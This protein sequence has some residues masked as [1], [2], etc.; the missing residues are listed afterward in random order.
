MVYMYL[1]VYEPRCKSFRRLLSVYVSNYSPF[2]LHVCVCV[3]VCAS[4]HLSLCLSVYLYVCESVCSCT[5]LSVRLSIHVFH[6][7]LTFALSLIQS[8]LTAVTVG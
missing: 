3:Y 8:G 5:Y 7:R 2:S 1:Y 4:I 6:P